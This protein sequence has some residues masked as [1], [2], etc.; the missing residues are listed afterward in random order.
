[1]EPPD[2]SRTLIERQP[3]RSFRGNGFESNYHGRSDWISGCRRGAWNVL[4]DT[5]VEVGEDAL[6][7]YRARARIEL[8]RGKHRDLV[9]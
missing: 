5:D 6:E 2:R 7:E 1:V 8:R 3:F 9:L 4:Y